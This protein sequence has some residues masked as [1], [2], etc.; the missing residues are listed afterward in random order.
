M[1]LAESRWPNQVYVALWSVNEAS[2]DGGYVLIQF[3][4]YMHVH[5]CVFARQPVFHLLLMP[6]GRHLQAANSVAT[7]TYSQSGFLLIWHSGLY[8]LWPE[9]NAH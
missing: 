4:L 5:V 7:R 8:V 3:I 1:S 2:G 6:G 9:N